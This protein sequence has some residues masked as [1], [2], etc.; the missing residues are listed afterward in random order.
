MAYA[1]SAGTRILS[2]D[3]WYSYLPLRYISTR[4]MSSAVIDC[5]MSTTIS[6]LAEAQT[7]MKIIPIITTTRSMIKSFW[8]TVRPASCA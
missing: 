8:L 7:V 2:P 5:G 4:L 3:I 6:V 1:C